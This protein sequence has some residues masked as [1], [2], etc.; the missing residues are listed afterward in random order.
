MC[1][2]SKE[3]VQIERVLQLR[4][5]EEKKKVRARMRNSMQIERVLQLRKHEEKKGNVH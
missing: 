3:W 4:K 1:T 5:Y 2:I